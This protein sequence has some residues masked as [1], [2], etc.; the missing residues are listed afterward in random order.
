MRTHISTAKLNNK[1]SHST[2]QR[3]LSTV[4]GGIRA[5]EKP[6]NTVTSNFITTI[7]IH[8]NEIETVH[9]ET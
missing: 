7:I 1:Y 5:S 8:V 9:I 3:Q 2:V 6:K 4:S